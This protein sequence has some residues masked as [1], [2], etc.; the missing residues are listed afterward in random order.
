VKGFVDYMN[1][2]K[3]VLHNN[4]FYAIARRTA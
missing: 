3:T 4:I 1:R 2:S